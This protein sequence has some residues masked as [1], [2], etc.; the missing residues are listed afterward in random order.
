[1]DYYFFRY[2]YYCCH[3]FAF[4]DSY[5]SCIRFQ[6]TDISEIPN[7]FRFVIWIFMCDVNKTRMKKKPL[8]IY[9]CVS[10][11]HFLFATK[12]KRTICSQ[13]VWIIWCIDRK[14]MWTMSSAIPDTFN[15]LRSIKSVEIS[16]DEIS[17]KNSSRRESI[18]DLVRFNFHKCVENC[19]VNLLEHCHIMSQRNRLF[20]VDGVAWGSRLFHS[21]LHGQLLTERRM[22]RIKFKN[23]IRATSSMH[24][25]SMAK[26]VCHRPGFHCS[27]FIFQIVSHL[28]LISYYEFHVI[29]CSLSLC[30]I[31]CHCCSLFI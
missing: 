6:W 7:H 31:C 9:N 18:W 10:C 13:S 23:I 29:F 11:A 26:I 12:K 1:M 24:Y 15:H 4:N 30:L 25:H 14:R 27:D 21:H 3:P 20:F 5:G 22:A 8:S 17:L 16:N 28:F 19:L 2:A